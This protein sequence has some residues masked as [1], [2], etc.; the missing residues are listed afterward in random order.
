[1]LKSGTIRSLACVGLGV[2]LGYVAMT[3][4]FDS[5]PVV[6]AEQKAAKAEAKAQLERLP[7]D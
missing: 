3:G 6:F 2:V 7:C 4:Q 1:M 5:T